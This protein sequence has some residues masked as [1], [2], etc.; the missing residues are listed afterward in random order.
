[1]VHAYVITLAATLVCSAISCWPAVAV[2]GVIA[3]GMLF[4]GEARALRRK[5]RARR[6]V[7][8]QKRRTAPA[9]L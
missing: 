4:A 6:V 1:M 5:H 7:R 3:L 8:T 9:A 2:L